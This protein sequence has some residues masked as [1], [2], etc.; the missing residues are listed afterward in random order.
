MS[1][2]DF[3]CCKCGDTVEASMPFARAERG[4]PCVKCEG[5]MVRQFSPQGTTFQIRWGKPKVRNK[6]KKMGA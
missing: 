2:F 5:I 4:F 1:R 3:K 6:V